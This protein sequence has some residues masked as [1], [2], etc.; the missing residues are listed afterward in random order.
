VHYELVGCFHSFFLSLGM[1]QFHFVVVASCVCVPVLR[2]C[3]RY[4]WSTLWPAIPPEWGTRFRI[5]TL[6]A[7]LLFA[8]D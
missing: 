7:L 4:Q 6:F 3:V 1:F 8:F 5:F 2:P